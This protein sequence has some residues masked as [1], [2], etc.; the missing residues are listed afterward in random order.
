MLYTFK[1]EVE[2]LHPDCHPSS[3]FHA[4]FPAFY[5][6]A[7]DAGRQMEGFGPSPEDAILAALEDALLEHGDRLESFKVSC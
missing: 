4:T 3:R 1:I 2:D 5:D 6:G 7:P